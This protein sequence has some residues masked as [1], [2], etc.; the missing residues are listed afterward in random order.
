MEIEKITKHFNDGSYVEY[1][2]KKGNDLYWHREDGPAFIRY[3]KNGSIRYEEYWINS[4]L[5]REDGPANIRYNPDGSIEYNYYY[6]NN[7]IISKEQYKKEYGWKLRLKNT[8]MGEIL[9]T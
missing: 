3:N 7:K 8:P 4:K 9:L 5:H 6:I 1:Y 2:H